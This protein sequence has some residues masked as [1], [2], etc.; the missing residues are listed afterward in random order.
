MRNRV[1]ILRGICGAGKTWLAEKEYPNALILSAADFFTRDGVWRWNASLISE[2]HRYCMRKFYRAI[3]A[4]E[5]L[6][7]VDNT[8]I[9]AHELTPYSQLAQSLDYTVEILRVHAPAEVAWA[10]NIHHVPLDKI[11]K[12][13]REMEKLPFWLTERFV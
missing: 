10:R 13:E 7:V 12:Q 2:S 1:I 5:P 3:A 6:I 11:K 8:N 4:G 9:Y